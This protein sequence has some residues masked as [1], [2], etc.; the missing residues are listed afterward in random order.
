MRHAG[1]QEIETERLV[2]RRLTPE[3]AGMMYQN[4]ANDPQV[5]K[6][7]RWEPHKN[8]AGDRRSAGGM[9]HP[10]PEPGL[11]PVGHC[12]KGFRAGVWQHQHLQCSAR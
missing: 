11:L 2:L 1:T 3:D 5:T 12:G 7:L 9:G 4:W 6:F 8:R 10:L